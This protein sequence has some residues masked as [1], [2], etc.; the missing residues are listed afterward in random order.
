[1]RT[2]LF[3]LTGF[4]LLGASVVLSKL[5]TNYYPAASTVAT[6]TFL[7]IWLSLTGFNMWVRVVKAGYSAAEELPIFLLLFAVPAVAA[8]LVKWKLL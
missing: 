8:V 4:L 5:F 3:L 6:A 1:M 2:G 7:A